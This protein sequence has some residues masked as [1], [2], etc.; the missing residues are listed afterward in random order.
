MEIT[1]ASAKL[2]E[3]EETIL[4]L[5]KHLKALGSAKEMAVVDKVLSITDIS[6]NKFKLR[7]SLREQMLHEDRA[8]LQHLDSP[9]TKETISMAKSDVQSVF[10]DEA[11][12]GSKHE[13]R[14]SNEGALVI[15]PSRR[16]GGRLGFL[17]KL[18]LKRK[19]SSHRNATFYF[20]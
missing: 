9:N 12:M 11:H 2:A 14:S 7:P 4:K 1:R 16:K 10:P 13:T 20:G 17:R 18:V 5:G 19:S 3:C 6:S 8:K 15:F